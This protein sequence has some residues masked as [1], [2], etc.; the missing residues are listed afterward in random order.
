MRSE[1][2][3]RPRCSHLASRHTKKEWNAP[4]H[5][6]SSLTPPLLLPP[7]PQVK[8]YLGGNPAIRLGLSDNLVLA[9]RDQHALSPYSSHEAVVLDTYSLHEAA[10]QES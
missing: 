3:R 6:A 9:R 1:R 8:S 7:C 4:D 10:D 5:T 2:L